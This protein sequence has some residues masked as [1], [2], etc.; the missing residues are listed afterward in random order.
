MTV[1]VVLCLSG[2]S[3]PVVEPTVWQDRQACE[4]ARAWIIETLTHW[5]LI[6]EAR[7]LPRWTEGERR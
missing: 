4:A 6:A 7:C 1:L 5:D 3:C 2:S